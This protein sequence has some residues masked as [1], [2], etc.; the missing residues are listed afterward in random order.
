MAKILV[1]EDSPTIR[2]MVKTFLE[3]E[4]YSVQL[5]SKME[6]A[7]AILNSSKIDLVLSDVIIES[8]DAKTGYH[9]LKHIRNTPNIKN[10]PVIIMTDRRG[11]DTAEGTAKRLG[12]SAFLKKPFKMNELAK[13]LRSLMSPVD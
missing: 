9:I 2:Q 12:A 7:V 4:G 8:K 3:D 13:L 6:D 1:V 11:S 5:C 10:I